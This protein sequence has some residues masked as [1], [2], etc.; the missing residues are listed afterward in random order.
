M[1]KFKK[2]LLIIIILIGVGVGV[3]YI[4]DNYD[5]TKFLPIA[6]KTNVSNETVLEINK[7]LNDYSNI[8]F[9]E[10]NY[11][12]LDINKL[13]FDSLYPLFNKN[14]E[15]SSDDNLL[16]LVS[17]SS[18]TNYKLFGSSYSDNLLNKNV[19]YSSAK[20]IE[21]IESITNQTF[22][23]SGEKSLCTKNLTATQYIAKVNVTK[24]V[25]DNNIY[26]VDYDAY[27]LSNQLYLQKNPAVSKDTAKTISGTVKLSNIDNRYIFIS[28]NITYG[29]SLY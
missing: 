11:K 22:D 24:V 5:I 27:E 6:S 4:L 26:T 8:G 19:C 16:H 21:H 2:G 14:Y 9:L 13:D 25:K 15:W 10:Y 3:K 28:N 23:A 7:F 12:N 18:S 17:L 20:L 29:N 1:T